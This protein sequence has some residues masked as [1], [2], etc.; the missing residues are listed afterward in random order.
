MRKYRDELIA[1]KM[2]SDIY[3]NAVMPLPLHQRIWH[4]IKKQIMGENK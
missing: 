4:W 2:M 1:Q 3:E